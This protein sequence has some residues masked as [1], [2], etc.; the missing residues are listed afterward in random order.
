M[1]ISFKKLQDQYEENDQ[2]HFAIHAN[3][4]M[5]QFQIEFADD[6]LDDLDEFFRYRS[7]VIHEFRALLVRFKQDPDAPAVIAAISKINDRVRL[8]QY[9]R[10]LTQQP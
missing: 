5:T 6:D 3:P 1:L 7:D 4:D 8:E 9:S 10:Q 2:L